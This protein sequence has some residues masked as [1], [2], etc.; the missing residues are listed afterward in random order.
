MISLNQISIAQTLNLLRVMSETRAGAD[1][2]AQP[3]TARPNVTQTQ[4]PPPAESALPADLPMTTPATLAEVNPGL[5][6]AG[7]RP[8]IATSAGQPAFASTSSSATSSASPSSS[9][10]DAIAQLLEALGHPQDTGAAGA[11]GTS[12]ILAP[13]ASVLAEGGVTGSPDQTANPASTQA[14]QTEASG[15]ETTLQLASAQASA[16]ADDRSSAI[17]AEQRAAASESAAALQQATGADTSAAD[18]HTASRP[19]TPDDGQRGD[20]ADSARQAESADAPARAATARALAPERGGIIASF[21]LNAAML[22]VRPLPLMAGAETEAAMAANG[23]KPV[24]NDE[25]ALQ[26][27][28]NLGAN[29]ALV[30][31]MRKTLRRRPVGKKLLLFLAGLMTALTVVVEALQRELARLA[32]EEREKEERDAADPHGR[33]DGRRRLYLE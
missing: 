12:A 23:R 6:L 17:A 15:A 1:G 18:V 22:P 27:L 10:T 5:S 16:A 9:Q 26:Y 32:E 33:S 24:M 7:L 21:I 3:V 19:E 30:D 29:P 11:A 2:P 4:A 8:P 20:P 25:E 13:P 14:V 31:K 28:V